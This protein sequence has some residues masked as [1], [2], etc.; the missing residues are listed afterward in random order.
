MEA[1]S[2]EQKTGAGGFCLLTLAVGSSAPIRAVNLTTSVKGDF[3]EQ[4]REQVRNVFF[5]PYKKEFNRA[6]RRNKYESVLK[7]GAD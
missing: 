4:H 1:S 5:S 6:S 3:L 2:R 7:V